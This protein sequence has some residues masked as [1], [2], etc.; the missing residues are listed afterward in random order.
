M[1]AQQMYKTLYH[2]YVKSKNFEKA[3]QILIN[4]SD[5]LLESKQYKLANDLSIDLLDLF[6]KAGYKMDTKIISTKEKSTP[7]GLFLFF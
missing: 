3:T 2:K 1:K 5:K 6:E 4:G 7:I